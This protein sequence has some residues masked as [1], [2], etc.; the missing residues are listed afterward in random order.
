MYPLKRLLN[1]SPVGV[2]LLFVFIVGC[3]NSPGH[4]TMSAAQPTGSVPDLPKTTA[5]QEIDPTLKSEEYIRLGLPAPG[6]VWSSADMMQANKVLASLTQERAEQL[7]RYKSPRSG[8]MFAR[9]TS[10]ESLPSFKDRQI[11]LQTRLLQAVDYGDGLKEIQKKYAFAFLNH[12]V[13]DADMVE[14]TGAFLRYLVVELDVLD[15]FILTL[16]KDDPK[17]PV[18]MRGLAQVKLGVYQI[19]TGL[20]VTL[21]ER[22]H[23]G[24]A[25]LVR[26]LSYMQE[27]LPAITPRMEASARTETVAR[28]QQLQDD[29][30]TKDLQPGLRELFEKV[31]DAVEKKKA[32]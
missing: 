2:L 15:E 14:L 13:R 1:G 30:N 24:S 22:D 27:T 9:L 6:T 25:E 28:L 12:K 23:Y 5:T 21:T 10:T 11:P 17:Y 18:R 29:P 26:L 16:D 4:T 19:V 7:P 32:P 31:K 20:V 8:E 3:G